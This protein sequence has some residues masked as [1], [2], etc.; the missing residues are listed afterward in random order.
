M[1]SQKKWIFF[2]FTFDSY[3]KMHL[4]IANRI[5][6]EYFIWRLD[7]KYKVD[8][9]IDISAYTDAI[10]NPAWGVRWFLVFEDDTY[11]VQWGWEQDG[12]IISSE[13]VLE[14]KFTRESLG[15]GWVRQVAVGMDG[16]IY[17]TH[18]HDDEKV[19]IGKLNIESGLVINENP[20]L[21][22]PSGELFHTMSGGT[23]T[24]LLLFSIYSGIWAYDTEGEIME[25]RM[26]LTDVRMG[27][28]K[29]S[30]FWSKLF[31]TRWT[32]IFDRASHK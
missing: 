25:N 2:N 15:V 28:D 1:K 6:E 32:T 9:V 29:D 3:G 8:R 20:D 12:I 24:N 17:I 13:G 22:F 4:L 26:S 10:Q 23:D 30:D 19:E 18:A 31:F 14:H 7:E 11:Y 21:Y 5:Q 27:M 16:H